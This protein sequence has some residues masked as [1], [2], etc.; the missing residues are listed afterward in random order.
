LKFLAQHPGRV[1]TRAHLLQEVWG[2]DYFGGTRTVDVH[3]RRLR[4]KLGAEHEALIGTVRNVGYRFVPLKAGED[5]RAAPRDAA[6]A[7]GEPAIPGGPAAGAAPSA[8]G[9]A[10]A[11]AGRRPGPPPPWTTA[12]PAILPGTLWPGAALAGSACP[13]PYEGAE[14]CPHRTPI[15]SPSPA[16]HGSAAPRPATQRGSP[17]RQP[18]PTA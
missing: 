5:R 8:D 4:A 15:R 11:R 13:A 10:P 2:Y 1:F 12:R 18:P 6:A 17:M 9:T 7:V 14:P 3:V 16:G